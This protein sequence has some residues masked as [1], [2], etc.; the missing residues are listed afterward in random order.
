M[1]KVSIQNISANIYITD[2]EGTRTHITITKPLIITVM[3][4]DQVFYV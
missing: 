4:I 3:Q 1:K 2:K